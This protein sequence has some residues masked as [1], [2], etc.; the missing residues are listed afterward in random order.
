M[1]KQ[2]SDKL[3]KLL[4]SQRDSLIAD[5][6]EHRTGHVEAGGNE[7]DVLDRA[8]SEIEMGLDQRI[9]ADDNQLLAKIE[10]ALERLENGTHEI[11]GV[12]KERI[13]LERL[14]AKPAVSLC[15]NCQEYK[16]RGGDLTGLA[17]RLQN[18]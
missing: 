7:A 6:E 13:P 18:S 8:E 4:L 10:L 2:D 17:A 1:R 5:I 15:L 12:C 3:R 14:L 11:C 9:L 16:E